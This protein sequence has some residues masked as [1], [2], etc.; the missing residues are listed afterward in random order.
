MLYTLRRD[1]YLQTGQNQGDQAGWLSPG[2]MRHI[3]C[4]MGEAITD[5]ELQAATAE[6]D[7]DGSGWVR[8]YK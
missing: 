4:L 5:D 7:R 3:C 8:V 6:L 1:V 2:T